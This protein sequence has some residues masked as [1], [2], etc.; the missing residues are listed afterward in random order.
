MKSY[1][2]SEEEN[3]YYPLKSVNKR[4]PLAAENTAD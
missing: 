2:K 3:I 1:S 4:R